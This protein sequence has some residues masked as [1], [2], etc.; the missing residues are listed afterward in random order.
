MSPLAH[1]RFDREPPD[2]TIRTHPPSQ[3]TLTAHNVQMPASPDALKSPDNSDEGRTTG[4]RAWAWTPMALFAVLFTVYAATHTPAPSADAWSAN[5]GSWQIVSTGVPWLDVSAFPALDDHELRDTW[6]ISRTDGREAIGRAPGVIAA[7]LPAYWLA[8][9]DHMTVA[10]GGLTAALLTA[11]G[12]TLF[13]LL[14]R[15]RI[16]NRAAA[17]G[18]LVLGLTT[19]VWSVAADALWP[20]TLTVLGILGMAWAADR[21]RW[22]LVGVFGGIALWGRLHA[23]LICAVLG[24]GLALYRRNPVIAVKV[25]ASSGAL[26][27]LMCGWTK[28]MYGSWDPTSAY[29]AGDFAEHASGKGLQVVNHLGFW[30]SPDRGILIWTPL[31]LLLFPALVR[32][33]RELPDWSRALLVG[34]LAYTLLQGTLNRFSGGDIFYGYRLGLEVVA[35]AAP[36]LALSARRMGTFARRAFTPIVS[37]QLLMI[38]PGSVMT[39]F[40]VPAE[41]VWTDSAFLTVVGANP[42]IFPLVAAAVFAAGWLFARIWMNPGLELRGQARVPS[43]SQ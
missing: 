34:G 13:Y 39:S 15:R 42:V 21:E 23:A 43:A 2:R 29:R 11:A 31:V 32:S 38:L 18:A 8:S 28:W 30:V 7:G 37:L 27:A 9:P 6:V 41:D 40:F 26:L 14:L 3:T 16:G 1:L 33:W 12:V 25:G 10:P 22:W 4:R 19:P 24:L 5:L 17:L 35:C 36:A 20:H